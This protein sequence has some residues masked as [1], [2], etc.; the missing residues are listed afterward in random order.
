MNAFYLWGDQRPP[1]MRGPHVYTTEP[2]TEKI[3]PLPRMVLEPVT[4]QTTRSVRREL[5][6]ELPKGSK[7]AER[8][9]VNPAQVD[10]AMTQGEARC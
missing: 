4:V 1:F 5:M 3:G 8:Y 6:V 7:L 2:V 10:A 9:K